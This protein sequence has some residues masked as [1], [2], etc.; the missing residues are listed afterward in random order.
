MAKLLSAIVVCVLMMLH[1]ENV[2]EAQDN[3][4]AWEV[5]LLLKSAGEIISVTPAGITTVATLPF[6]SDEASSPILSADRTSMLLTVYQ[7]NEMTPYLIDLTGSDECCTDLRRFINSPYPSEEYLLGYYPGG[8]NPNNPAQIAVLE[9][10]VTR[11]SEL[12][13]YPPTITQSI[14]VVDMEQA[15][16]VAS[17]QDIRAADLPLIGWSE[18]GIEFISEPGPGLPG[19]PMILANRQWAQ[20]WDPL[21]NAIA[22]SNTLVITSTDPILQIDTGDTLEATGETVILDYV[23][24][25]GGGPAVPRTYFHALRYLPPVTDASRRDQ[26]AQYIHTEYLPEEPVIIEPFPSGF[27]SDFRRAFWIADGRAVLVSVAYSRILRVFEGRTSVLYFRDGTNIMLSTLGSVPLIG[28]PDGWLALGSPQDNRA[29]IHHQL[30]T[31][32]T[33]DSAWPSYNLR[34]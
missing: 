14:Y 26:P 10:S 17:V 6:A 1:R 22:L 30:G 28:T 11:G 9:F 25:E 7:S 15:R 31:D 24:T 19:G 29:L 5:M 20:A 8:F 2:A 32:G 16:T 33:T 3:V 13:P 23:T 4:P 18:A 34:I 12:G 27:Q 21:T